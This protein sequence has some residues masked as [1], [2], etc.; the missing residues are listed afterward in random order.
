MK[1]VATILLLLLLALGAASAQNLLKSPDFASLGA[2]EAA[3]APQVKDGSVAEAAAGPEGQKALHLKAA[4]VDQVVN[5]PAGIYEITAQA[6]GQGELAF[7]AQNAGAR[8]QNLGKDW[9]TYGYLFETAGGM[10]TLTVGVADDGFVAAASLLPA[11]DEQKTAWAKAQESLAQFGWIAVS[12]QRPSPGA[13]PLQ[14]TGNVK[15]LEAMTKFAVLDEPRLSTAWAFNIDRAVKW[16]GD[17]G[18]ERLD[19]EKLP[20]WMQE[21]IAKGEAYGS[22]VVLP[23]GKSPLGIFEGPT[24]NPLWL[25]YIKAGGRIVHA[26]DIALNYAE[27]PNVEPVSLDLGARGLGLVLPC[28]GWSSP[29]WGQGGLPTTISPAGKAWGFENVDGPIT[30]FGADEVSIAFSI[31]TVPA[32]GK[33][34]A[35]SWMVNRAPDMPWSGLIKFLQRFDGNNDSNLR[36]LWRAS[37]YIGKPVTIPA[38]PPPAESLAPK[39]VLSSLTGLAKDQQVTPGSIDLTSKAPAKAGMKDRWEWVRGE[40][41]TLQATPQ[42]DLKATAVRLELVRGDQVVWKQEQP[43]LGEAKPPAAWFVLSTAPYAYGA[44]QLKATALAGEVEAGTLAQTVGVRYIAPEYFNFE[45]WQGAS[46]NPIRSN[47]EFADI[48]SHHMEVYTGASAA[49]LDAAIRNGIGFSLRAMPNFI[50]AG[51]EVTWE[52]N[53]EYYRLD[54][55]GKPMGN[56][57]TAGRPGLGISHPDIVAEARRSMADEIRPAA[58]I[59]AF[60]PYVL[61]NDDF[62]IYYGW[63]Y[64]QH[65]LDAFKAATGLDA[66][67]KMEKPAKPGPI[68][69][70]DPWSSWFRWTLINVDGAFNK[71]QTEGC[72]QADPQVRVGPIPGGMQIPLVQLWEPAQYPPYNFGKNGFNLLCSYYYNTY[73]QPVMTTTFWMEIARMGN[74]DLPEWCLPDSFMTAGY[75]RN[76]LFHYLAGGVKGLAYFTYDQRNDNTWPEFGKLGALLQRIGPVQTALTPAKRDIGMLNSFTSNCFEPGHTLIQVYGYHNLVQAH[77]DVEPVSEDEIVA[78]RA[79]QYKAILLYNVQYLPQSVYDALVAHAAK[80][81]L[82]LLDTS[83]PFELPG[84]KRLTVD[85]GMGT[86]HTLPMPPEGAHVSTPGLRDYGQPDRIALIQKALAQYVKPRI[87]CSDIKIAAWQLQAGGV[88]YTYFVNV[89][90]GKEYMFCRERM[91]AG[92]PG[93]G[94]PDKVQELRAWEKAETAKGPYT[95][96]VVMAPD[97]A[98]PRVPYDLVAMKKIPCKKLADGRYELSLSVERFAGMLVAWLPEEIQRVSLNSPAAA[99]VGQV[100]KAS[101]TIMGGK[102]APG[103]LAVEFIL[104]GPN[105]KA[106]PVSGVRQANTGSAAFEWTP[107]VNDPLG[108]WALEARELVTGKTAKGNLKLTR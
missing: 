94:T 12:P 8:Y 53:P 17:N 42:A 34:G 70:N 48:A 107:A 16:L 14:F 101:A 81:G 52:K 3:W 105:G 26:G 25:A 71:A 28:M 57:Y 86:E 23:R 68:A 20:V 41:V 104:T 90:D 60:R 72:L 61:C 9:A 51:K 76:D 103:V 54:N 73:W 89:H 24:S 2:N 46:D 18:F 83:V 11:T 1:H 58:N 29:Y 80:G 15:P 92:H 40:E 7:K 87:E 35:G 22:V 64:S 38:L 102:P 84:A 78:G 96:T 50:P 63:D 44:Y 95:A 10:T 4:S 100:Y 30:G 31:Y 79:G 62:S 27:S 66:P 59:P 98:G 21:R 82:V 93:S 36:D 67:R 39:V 108:T 55:N 69:E 97:G 43:V 49:N 77:F 47:L 32:T 65:V 88:P 33:Q 37:H 5:L 99:K 13:A 85:I 19:G 56:P 6:K 75:T 45:A 74:R 91:G 106:Y